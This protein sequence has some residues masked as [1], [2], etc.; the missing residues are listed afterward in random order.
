MMKIIAIDTAPVSVP[1]ERH[2]GRIEE[3]KGFN[4]ASELVLVRVR[5]D[6][7]LEGIGEA[8]GSPDW[9]GETQGGA[10]AIIDDHFAPRLIGEDPRR[11]RHALARLDSIRGNPFAKAAIEMALFDILGKALGAPVYQLL[12][13]A[14]RPLELPLRFPLMPQS[15]Q[16]SAEAARRMAGEGF[17][18][19]KLKVGRDPLA[20]DLE[21]VR[22][23]RDAVGPEV[24]LSV[25]ANGH[26]S[27][28]EAIRAARPLEQ[29]DVSFIEQPVDRRDLAGLAEVRRRSR[30]PIMADEAVFTPHDALECLRLGAA[31][32]ISVYPGKNG[33]ILNTLA[34]VSMAEAAG[35][36]C[37]IGSNLESDIASAAMA[38]LAV[39]LPNVG[40]ESYATDIIGPFMHRRRVVRSPLAFHAGRVTA[41]SG[42]GL[43]VEVDWSELTG[44]A[45]SD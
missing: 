7:G 6:Q 2:I 10:K 15:V 13:G 17:G 4:L 3:Q 11:I 14:V 40:V 27:V 19:I 21:R 5:T 24:R 1:I 22:V 30:L 32:I 31:D 9:N 20:T 43:G 38:H 33:G 41:P 16:N 34:I 37:A 45:P 8:T 26:W 42:P 25:D 39:A 36:E 18:T 44:R 28:H 29:F 23:V 12:G 35:V